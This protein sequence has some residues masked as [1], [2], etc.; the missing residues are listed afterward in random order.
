M[1]SRKNYIEIMD[2]TLRDGE[3]TPG[4]SFTPEEKLHLARTLLTRAKIDRLEIGSARVSAGERDGVKAIIE[5]ANRRGLIDSIEIL[6]FIDNGKSVDWIAECGGKVI[7]LLA[8]GSRRHCTIQLRKT[9]EEHYSEVARDVKYALERG[10]S[11]NVYLEDW[12]GGMREDFG[13]VYSMIRALKDLDIKRFMLPD[14]LGIADPD[15]ISRYFQW[16]G[17]AFP[18]VKFEF[19]GH[20]DYGMVTAN[21]L[22]AVKAGAA[23]I[24]TTINGLG[25]RTGNQPL[26]QIAVAIED[27]TP[28]TTGIAIKQLQRVSDTVQNMSGKRT[29]W[30]TPVTGS[31]VFTQT[32]GVHA[33]GDKKGNLY[34]NLLLPER[35]GRSRNYALGKLA[36]K[37]SLDKNL[38]ELGME[39][40]EDTRKK[41]L[42]EIVR[43]GDRKK[44]VANT[45][46]PF[47][48]SGVLRT[49]V[50]NRLKVESYHLESRS[51]CQAKA[52]VVLVF[53][54]E[55]IEAQAVGDGGFDAFVKAMRKALKGKNVSFPK[56]LDFEQRIPPG[57][58]T[59]ALV[60]ASIMWDIP[61]GKPLRTIGVDSDQVV[62]AIIATEKMLNQVVK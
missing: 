60:E 55:K 50:H 33:D 15:E 12:T 24:H 22:A 61:G 52:D 27:M 44:Q 10:L 43:L 36:G 34:A 29:A 49:P 31:D 51:G 16:L 35:F 59:D 2:T 40:D 23:G 6:G 26:A 41:V 13:Y 56:L 25:E 54:D 20:N 48:I 32:C 62:A 4:V 18:G 1:K 8:K 17:N 14:T 5:W 42:A 30:N 47:I 46:L 57:G 39:L 7:N 11:V 3:Q 9:P 38:E 19:H 21:S 28:F 58:K 45:D 37:A 53:D